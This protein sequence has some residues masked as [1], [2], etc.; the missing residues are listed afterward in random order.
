MSCLARSQQKRSYARGSN[1][2]S[3]VASAADTCKQQAIQKGLSCATGSIN[4]EC[5]HMHQG[6]AV[7]G[8]ALWENPPVDL[9]ACFVKV[10]SLSL[11]C[12]HLWTLVVEG[13]LYSIISSLL[14]SIQAPLVLLQVPSFGGAV[15]LFAFLSNLAR[16]CGGCFSK[17]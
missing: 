8:F 1:R 5:L 14:I 3:Y 11:G 10:C 12:A 2:Q 6:K 4:E 15:I 13:G 16:L 9:A 17:E 7:L